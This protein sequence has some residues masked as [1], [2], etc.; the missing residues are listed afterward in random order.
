MRVYLATTTDLLEVD[1]DDDFEPVFASDLQMTSQNIHL[2]TRLWD[3]CKAFVD[4]E[5]DN[6]LLRAIYSDR[7][8]IV[9]FDWD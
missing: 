2:L 5:S 6:G 1:V 7:G 3:V 8:S 9:M 4:V